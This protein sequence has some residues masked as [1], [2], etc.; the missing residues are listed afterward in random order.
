MNKTSLINFRLSKNRLIL[1]FQLIENNK[2]LIV[3]FKKVLR[4]EM[5]LFIYN[6]FKYNI[7]SLHVKRIEKS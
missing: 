3:F 1:K 4:N 7:L 6:L 2:L 5:I